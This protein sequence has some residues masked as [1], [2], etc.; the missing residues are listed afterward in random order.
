MPRASPER[1]ITLPADEQ[2]VSELCRLRSKLRSGSSQIEIPHSGDSHCDIAVAVAAGVLEL[3]LHPRRPMR[4]TPAA[5]F[6]NVQI[7]ALRPRDR[8][9][10]DG[11]NGNW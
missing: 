2:L 9:F 1:A 5:D 11:A 8:P 3:D 6:R 10:Y 7:G 4:V